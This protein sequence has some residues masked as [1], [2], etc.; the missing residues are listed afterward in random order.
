MSED[1]RESKLP[2]VAIGVVALIGIAAIVVWPLFAHKEEAAR[3]DGVPDGT[4]EELVKFI[5]SELHHLETSQLSK[6]GREKSLRKIATAA[7]KAIAGEPK[8]EAVRMKAYEAKAISL[9]VLAGSGDDDAATRLSAFLKSLEPNKEPAIRKFWLLHNAVGALGGDEAGRKKIIAE[10]VAYLQ[11]GDVVNRS[12]TAAGV[13]QQFEDRGFKSSAAEMYSQ[14]AQL[15][16]AAKTP[17]SKLLAKIYTGY[18]RRN[19]LVSSKLTVLSGKTLDGESIEW[20][21]FKGKVVLIDFWASWC[22]PCVAEIPNVRRAYNKYRDRG[23]EV[24][25]VNSDRDPEEL[26]A[27]LKKVHVPWKSIIHEHAQDAHPLEYYYGIRGIPFT[28][29][30]DR[31]GT[32]VATGLRGEDLHRQLA[33]L[34]ESDNKVAP[35][36]PSGG[37]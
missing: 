27:F 29:L 12:R 18:A 20:K 35:N 4:P 5:E 6:A 10:T 22:G 3:T 24:I 34:F 37:D 33:R 19:R 8:D 30:V 1:P 25:G 26:R 13:G 2:V 28:I 31:D 14:T 32:V 15:L 9:R 16:K 11:S 21:D 36:P 7:D 17:R 23:F